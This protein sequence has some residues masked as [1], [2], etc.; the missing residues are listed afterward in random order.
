MSDIP[1]MERVLAALRASTDS[2]FSAVAR[3][4]HEVRLIRWIAAS[5]QRSER[6]RHMRKRPGEGVAGEVIRFG[7]AVV[8]GYGPDDEKRSDDFM[9]HA[10]KLLVAAAVPI[11]AEDGRQGVLLIGRRTPIPYAD[12]ELNVLKDAARD[13]K[14]PVEAQS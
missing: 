14:L 5:G 12:R 6:Y 9:M 4:E 1:S 3:Y 7:T 8:R 2:D 10:E 13:M 11:E